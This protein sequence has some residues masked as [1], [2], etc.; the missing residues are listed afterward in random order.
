MRCLFLGVAVFLASSVPLLAAGADLSLS[1]VSPDR[2]AFDPQKGE[3]L[4]LRFRISAPA[5][6]KVQF[7]DAFDD[8]VRTLAQEEKDPGDKHVVWDGRDDQGN[9]VPAEAYFYTLSATPLSADSATPVVYDL[10]ERSGGEPVY[11]AE[12]KLDPASGKLSYVLPQSSRVRVIISQEAHLWPIVTLLDWAPR[13]AGRHEEAWDGWDQN[14]LVNAR[15]MPGLLPIFYAF[16]LPENVVFVE[17]VA[18]PRR[19]ADLAKPI[20]YLLS[21]SSEKELHFHALHPRARCYDPLITVSFPE[22]AKRT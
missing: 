18:S 10:R 9:L 8:V 7:I 15:E 5:R 2:S 6:V 13:T 4:S 1:W 11:P 16:S 17:G 12:A 14:H 20:G 21:R 22:G 19:R 3:K